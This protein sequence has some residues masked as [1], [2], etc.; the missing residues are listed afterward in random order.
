MVAHRPLDHCRS[1]TAAQ[2]RGGYLVG[3]VMIV[4]PLQLACISILLFLILLAVS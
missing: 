2:H 1:G 4:I 3:V